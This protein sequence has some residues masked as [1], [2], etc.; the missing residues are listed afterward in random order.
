MLVF[1]ASFCFVKF[2]SDVAEEVGQDVEQDV[3][4]ISGGRPGTIIHVWRLTIVQ[5]DL[6]YCPSCPTM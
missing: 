5:V 3:A 2:S 4:R 6:R 1:L